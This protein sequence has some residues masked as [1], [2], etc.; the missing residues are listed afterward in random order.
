[1]RDEDVGSE[2]YDFDLPPPAPSL[3]PPPE[4]IYEDGLEKNGPVNNT[5]PKRGTSPYYP[6]DT[7]ATKVYNKE[8]RMACFKE[9]KKP[10]RGKVFS[11]HVKMNK[12]KKRIEDENMRSKWLWFIG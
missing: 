11:E 7:Q 6:V 3:T 9:V 5:E 8:L 4:M 2:A 1:M 12:E 10:G